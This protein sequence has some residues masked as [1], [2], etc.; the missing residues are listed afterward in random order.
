MRFLWPAGLPFTAPVPRLLGSYDDGRWTALIFED[1]DGVLPAQPWR[2]AE[3]ERVLATLTG[4]AERLTPAPRLTLPLTPPRLGGWE[5][6]THSRPALAKLSTIAPR[7]AADLDLHLSLE[8]HLDDVI[9]GETLT[10]G[11]LYP[12]NILLTDDQV[13]FVDWPHAW[14]GPAH[15]DLVMLLGS[16]AL[17]GIDPEPFAARHPLLTGVAPEAVDVLIS[18]QA[19]SSW[20]RRAQ[21]MPLQTRA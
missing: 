8:A 3:L 2:E 1:V 10:H 5:R 11:D 7:A 20:R 6:L 12:F 19:D 21:Q 13:V 18:A 15:A 4:L 17:S 14:I 9:A 16:A